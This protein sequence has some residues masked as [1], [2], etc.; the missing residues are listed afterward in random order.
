MAKNIKHNSKTFFKYIRGKEQVRTS[1]GP[2]R[3]S[4]GRVVSDENEMAGLLNRYFSSTFTQEQSGELQ[5]AKSIYQGGEEGLLQK[6]QVGMEEVK[7]QL[8]NTRVDKVQI[9]ST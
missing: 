1:V 9:I 4:T 6:I 8:A 2:L 3:N 7:E 5:I